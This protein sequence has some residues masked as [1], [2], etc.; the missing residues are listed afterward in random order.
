MKTIEGYSKEKYTDTSVLLAGGGA[1]ALSG[2]IGS[3]SWDSTNKKIKY[4]PANGGSETDLVTLNWENISGKPGSFAPS[5]HEHTYIKSKD[6]YTF[7]S[8]TL[9]KSFDFGISA[10]FVSSD[11]G[12]GSYGSVL[13]VR[14][15]DGGGGSLQLY[16]PY[17]NTYGG[18]RLKARFGNYDSALG[19]SWTTL[20]EIAWL[21]DIP[22]S[23]PANGGNADTAT[24]LMPE[25]TAHYFRDPNNS[26]W[27]GGMIWGSTGNESMSFVV[28]HNN[29]RF[30]FV[31]GSDIANWTSSTWQSV[32]PY[33]TIYS[34]GIVTPGSATASG[35]FIKSGYNDTY[36][37]LAGGGHK[38]E[39]NLSVNYA[40][41]ASGLDLNRTSIKTG[42]AGWYKLA[43]YAST[44]PRGSVRIG[45]I[46]TG[47][48]FVPFY[49]ELYVE[50]GWS[51][52]NMVLY[53]RFDYISTLRFT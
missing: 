29:T 45:L 34:S 22:T 40:N 33:L 6:N 44:D 39:S 16:A 27:R 53:G 11:S 4:T 17:S 38:L 5:A 15:Y 19:N 31:G 21:E 23:L 43:Y 3:L 37:L 30:Q 13:T 2:F 14:T 48:S 25:N 18:S 32:T 46:T 8:S 50:N 47:G 42:A 1:K 35:G 49:A 7:T 51:N 26:A 12:F 10:G 24:N 9:P 28:T 52:I 20:K 41:T 36:V